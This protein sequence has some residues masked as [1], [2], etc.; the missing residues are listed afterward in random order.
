MRRHRSS[1]S[2]D[3]CTNR[4]V[5]T[6]ATQWLSQNDFRAI[7]PTVYFFRRAT[8]RE[9]GALAIRSDLAI[10]RL[11][12]R[13]TI[14]VS[15]L[16]RQMATLL[17]AGNAGVIAKLLEMALFIFTPPKIKSFPS[18]RPDSGQNPKIQPNSKPRNLNRI[19]TKLKTQK[20]NQNPTKFRP[21]S[22]LPHAPVGTVEDEGSGQVADGPL[23]G[24]GGRRISRRRH[25]SVVGLWRWR[26]RW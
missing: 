20:S 19:P 23:D 17:G 25:R 1:D 10:P 16:A 8:E 5:S 18:I 2:D 7:I 9:R 15:F 24:E 22:D 3:S 13:G 14:A 26:C 4:L 12:W 21:D 6:S 11:L